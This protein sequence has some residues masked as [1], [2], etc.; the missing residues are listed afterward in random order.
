[1]GLGDLRVVIVDGGGADDEIGALHVLRPVADGH[2]D[3]QGAEVLHR[4]A[5]VHIRA[6]DFDPHFVEHLGQRRHG[7]AADAHQMGGTAGGQIVVNIGIGHGF[8]HPFLQIIMIKGQHYI[9]VHYR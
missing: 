8:T 2:R 6:G 1:M 5:V 9:I 7:D 4:G 3:A